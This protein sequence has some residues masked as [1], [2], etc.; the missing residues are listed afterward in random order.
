MT[1]PPQ[2]VLNEMHASLRFDV[3]Y[4]ISKLHIPDLLATQPLS[5][6][7]LITTLNESQPDKLLRVL[8]AARSSGYLHKSTSGQW[9]NNRLSSVLSTTHPASLRAMVLMKHEDNFLPWE[10]LVEHLQLPSTHGQDLFFHKVHGGASMWEYLEADEERQRQFGDAMACYD[11]IGS[12]GPVHDFDWSRF[13]RILDMGGNKGSFL[14]RL[15]DAHPQLHGVVFDLPDVIEKNT[16]SFWNAKP[17]EL[18]ERISLAAGS[19]FDAATIPRGRNGDAYV[20]RIILHDWSDSEVVAIL[21]NIRAAIGSSAAASVIIVEMLP[22]PKDPLPVRH[23][24][25]L[26]MMVMFGG[27]ERTAAEFEP[28]L[29]MAGFKTVAVVEVRSVMRVLEAQ[30]VRNDET[31]MA[32]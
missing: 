4:T 18:R 16:R 30:P 11:T 24:L 26:H 21:K 3:I 23:L 13:K 20:L 1:P 19:F 9:H 29:R 27:A 2:Q 12:F 15:L 6:S 14:S 32:C 5:L 31:S 8:Q 17:D 25:D 7:H 28:L 10:F 22:G